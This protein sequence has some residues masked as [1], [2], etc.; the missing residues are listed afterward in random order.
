MLTSYKMSTTNKSIVRLNVG[1]E[2]FT[3]SIS[4]LCLEP[5]S[6]L[7]KLVSEQWFNQ[8]PQPVSSSQNLSADRKQSKND[9]DEVAEIFIDRYLPKFSVNRWRDFSKLK[10]P[11]YVCRDGHLFHHVLSYLRNGPKTTLP[12]D[13]EFTLQQIKNEADFFQLKV[14]VF[15]IICA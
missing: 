10:F 8:Q 6:M 14:H 7:A 3:T 5:E 13:S 11:N 1:G 4:T 15:I 2:K 9:G 12:F